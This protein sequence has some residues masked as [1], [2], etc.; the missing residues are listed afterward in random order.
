[1]KMKLKIAR[2]NYFKH[3]YHP[4]V[5][6]AVLFVQ[7]VLY[8]DAFPVASELDSRVLRY[9]HTRKTD[10]GTSVRGEIEE[11]DRSIRIEENYDRWL[12][13]VIEENSK[14]P[15]EMMFI[16]TTIKWK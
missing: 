9:I 15:L 1:G 12:C 7:V 11:N 16:L 10:V 3:Q 4:R 13:D 8:A 5:C 14:I 2:Q 6:L